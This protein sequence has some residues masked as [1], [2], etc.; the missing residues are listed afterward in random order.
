M[1][2]KRA[3]LFVLLACVLSVFGV[4]AACDGGEG[5]QWRAVTDI[6]LTQNDAKMRVGEE[7]TLVAIVNPSNATDKAVTW[8][9]P[10][11]ALQ[12]FRTVW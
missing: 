8:L 9:L 1:F 12:P 3:F 5:S 2:K 11:T 7:I 6:V 10:T 4:F